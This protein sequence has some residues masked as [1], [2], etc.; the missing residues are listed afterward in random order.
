MRNIFTSSKRQI[1]IFYVQHQHLVLNVNLFVESRAL[2]LEIFEDHRG[3]LRR[4]RWIKDVA[5]PCRWFGV[6]YAKSTA[7]R[8]PCTMN[9]SPT[10]LLAACL[11]VSSPTFSHFFPPPSSFHPF[12]FLQLSDFHLP[13]MILSQMDATRITSLTTMFRS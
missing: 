2:Y 12:S 11:Q 8:K 5:R 3:S 4:E 9:I 6:N 7:D 10:F 13:T 1:G